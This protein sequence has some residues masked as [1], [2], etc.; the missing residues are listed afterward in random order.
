[1]P[2]VVAILLALL[3]IVLTRSF[4]INAMALKRDI[5]RRFDEL[6][7][8]LES[9]ANATL[10]GFLKANAGDDSSP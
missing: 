7:V 2:L 8:R 5:D 6:R 4:A 10:D 9:E 3:V 1:M